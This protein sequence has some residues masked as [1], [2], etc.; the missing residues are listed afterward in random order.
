MSLKYFRN[1]HK[2]LTR[3]EFIA[4]NQVQV[5]VSD[6][7]SYLGMKRFQYSLDEKRYV[8]YITEQYDMLPHQ[9]K[10]ALQYFYVIKNHLVSQCSQD[11]RTLDEFTASDL[12][13]PRFV[14]WIMTH[15]KKKDFVRPL[16]CD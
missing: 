15:Y 1:E 10:E 7:I 8:R 6:G 14:N 13:R 11:K 12:T 3:L 5:L 9:Q 2:E 4:D 16:W